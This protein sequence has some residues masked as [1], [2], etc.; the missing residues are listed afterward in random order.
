MQALAISLFIGT[1]EKTLYIFITILY[2]CLC[3]RCQNHMT[4]AGT[5][6]VQLINETI[7]NLYGR[8]LLKNKYYFH[9]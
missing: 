3:V 7:S 4:H 6:P 2:V 1:Y 9:I 5:G 8:K